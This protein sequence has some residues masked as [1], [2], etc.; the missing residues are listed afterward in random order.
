MPTL[1][2]DFVKMLE[3]LGCDAT[4]LPEAL[5]DTTA[6]TSVRINTAKGAQ[7]AAGLSAVPWCPTGFY[8]PVR[9]LFAADPAWHQ[10]LYYVQEAS[11]MAASY[12]MRQLVEMARGS[13]PLRVLDAC[14]APGG[15]TI[16]ILECLADDDF[17]VANEYDPRRCDILLENISKYGAANVAV[18]RADARDFASLPGAFNIIA[19]DV[20]CSGEG[21]MRKEEVA[22]TQWSPGLVEQCAG[23]QRQILDSLWESL[24]PDGYLLY[25]TCTFNTSE[26]EDNLRYMI[27][28]KG[29]ES[30][31]LRLE[32]IEGVC[33]SV[34]GSIHACR[35]YPG[36]VRGEGQFV[37]ALHKPAQQMPQPAHKSRKNSTVKPVVNPS[38][39]LMLH[40]EQYICQGKETIYAVASAHALFVTELC[41]RIKTVRPGLPV[42][43]LKGRE[44]V[45]THELVT[46]IEYKPDSL[47]AISVDTAQALDYLR[48][49]ALSDLPPHIKRGYFVA[50][51]GGN[52]LGLAKCVG[53]RAN[54][55]YPSARRLR[56]Q[57]S[58]ANGQNIQIVI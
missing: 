29:A 33:A 10:G 16:G 36:K 43:E 56:L 23:L 28:Q 35:F 51:H 1:P 12:A 3:A 2:A 40:P 38:A 15:K 9:E 18:T 8:L 6:T 19:A 57:P 21:M 58:A 42:A 30:V 25:S 53:N 47:P 44:Y 13:E 37:A 48:G 22:V 26:N 45:P 7:G 17:V 4:G 52:V 31:E 54:N 5:A 34:E 50:K 49:N 32:G 55:L 24:A 11:S 46:S 41:A 39:P 20:P 14:A 27:E